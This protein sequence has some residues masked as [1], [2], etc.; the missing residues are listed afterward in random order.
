M[1]KLTTIG[2]YN[3][4]NSLFEDLTFPEGINKDLAVN[5]ILMRSGE[6]EVLYPDID[7]MK[8]QI[9]LWGQKHYRTFEKWIEGLSEDFNPIYNFDRYEEYTDQ[10][11]KQ[12]AETSSTNTTTATNTND[13]INVSRNDTENTSRNLSG[14][15][16]NKVSAY[17]SATYQP[18]DKTESSETDQ[19]A[20][21]EAE[22]TGTM[23]TSSQQLAE[24]TSGSNNSSENRSL[25][26]TAHLYGNIGVTTSA[27]LLE[28]FLRVQ[29]WNI[30]EHIADL[31]VEEFCLM[32]Y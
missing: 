30:Y 7:F 16:E 9:A 1:A 20:R 13:T 26:H 18:K 31:F 24:N 27:A 22:T 14:S 10:E 12:N 23:G 28:E 25:N 5:A 17:D 21:T 32:I 4:D 2:L 11:A 19:V 15:D 29:T 3:Y 8:I 6:F